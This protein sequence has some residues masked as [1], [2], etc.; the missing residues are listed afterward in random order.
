MSYAELV[1]SNRL[2]VLSS[3]KYTMHINDDKPVHHQNDNI[4]IQV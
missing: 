2:Q 4:S 1:F 3:C